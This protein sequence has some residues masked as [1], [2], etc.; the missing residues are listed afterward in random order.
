MMAKDKCFELELTLRDK[1]M[2]MTKTGIKPSK[3][4]NSRTW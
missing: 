3:K 2:K 1:N 4:K